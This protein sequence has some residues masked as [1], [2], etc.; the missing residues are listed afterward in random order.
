MAET[1]D[2]EEII[3][4]IYPFETNLQRRSIYR[5]SLCQVITISHLCP[6]NAQTGQSSEIWHTND[7]VFSVIL[8]KSV[9]SAL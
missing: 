2:Q 3:T 1:K 8:L 9:P 5:T 6:V 4:A 7:E